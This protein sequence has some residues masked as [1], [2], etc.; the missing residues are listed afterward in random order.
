MNSSDLTNMLVEAAGGQRLPPNLNLEDEII[1]ESYVM[2]KMELELFTFMKSFPNFAK[3]LHDKKAIEGINNDILMIIYKYEFSI[4]DE[5]YELWYYFLCNKLKEGKKVVNLIETIKS[6]IKNKGVIDMIDREIRTESKINSI[7]KKMLN[8]SEF[9]SIFTVDEKLLSKDELIVI[10][11]IEKANQKHSDILNKY[12][13]E[14]D[15]KEDEDLIVTNFFTIIQNLTDNQQKNKYYNLFLLKIITRMNEIKVSQERMKQKVN[16]PKL[17]KNI[18][19]QVYLYILNYEFNK[20]V[21]PII[22]QYFVD[23]RINWFTYQVEEFTDKLPPHWNF[24]S[25][26]FI[27]DKSQKECIKK[28]DDKKNILLCAPTSYGKTLLSTRARRKYR[29]VIFVVPTEPLAYQVAGIIYVDEIESEKLVGTVKK[30]IRVKLDSM[31]YKRFG[32]KDDDL[33][34]TTPKQLY[35]MICTKEV[36]TEIDYIILDEFHN[37]SYTEGEYYEYI[38][39]FAGMY[40]ISTMCLSATI[41]NY[42]EL[43]TWLSRVLYG[44]IYGV[45]EIKRFFNQKRLVIQNGEI[46]ELD[47]LEHLTIPT[48]RSQVTHIGLHPRQIMSLYKKLEEFPRISETDREFVTLDKMDK[49]ERNMI[50]Y[51]KEL[52]DAKL[53]EVIS[54]KPIKTDSLSMYDLY[55]LL[56]KKSTKMKPM[57]IFKMDAKKCS[58]IYHKL[59][60]LVKDYNDLV[61]D[62]FNDDQA[63]IW[64]YLNKCEELTGKL[65]TR[66]GSDDKEAPTKD[67][68]EE[69]KE[70][71]KESVF[72]NQFLPAITEFFNQYKS[73]PKEKIEPFIKDFNKNYDGDL[74]YEYII[75]KRKEHIQKELTKYRGKTVYR[76]KTYLMHD[77]A[78]LT[79]S[80]IDGGEMKKIK[81][82]INRELT[83]GASIKGGKEESKSDEDDD[84][85]DDDGKDCIMNYDDPFMRG[86]EFGILCYNELMKPALQRVTQFMLSKYKYITFTDKLLAVGINY[87]IKTVMLLGGMKG[88]PKEEVDNSLAHQAIGRAGRRGL[89]KEG[90]V[91]YSGVNIESILIQ[92]YRNIVPNDP[93]IMDELM[94]DDSEEFK[95][96]VKTGKRPEIKVA[97][98]AVVEVVVVHS[99]NSASNSAAAPISAEKAA[100]FERIGKA[101]IKLY[102]IKTIEWDEISNRDE[103][104]DAMIVAEELNAE[105][106]KILEKIE[107]GE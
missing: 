47:P 17:Y 3:L 56:K 63:I 44:E 79:D 40:K 103:A 12:I 93:K 8:V 69:K 46:V 65:E 25:K 28:I 35:E 26:E 88:E 5:Y 87:P 81:K 36:S 71:I 14:I 67:D 2:S 43:Y 33:I 32:S 1:D 52:P 18:L 60:Q 29:K 24:K 84:A 92:K 94:K 39:N 53:D 62:N 76:R 45:Y 80:T 106:T 89:D 41:P 13:E 59:V 34:I 74:T 11:N 104:L 77:E 75:K 16:I 22:T 38:L 95:A 100:L 10:S 90:L 96:F 48:L 7:I 73:I 61:Y 50:K 30:N 91:I 68:L 78:K 99:I 55:N 82:R 21:D 37:I 6:R 20:N 58:E 102:E 49:I 98:K 54:N 51:L 105:Q 107:R 66:G 4:R 64:A 27:L 42:D 57:L 23:N 31:D 19:I 86:I 72:D 101:K 9:N 15:F 97:V 85:E 70:N 83:R